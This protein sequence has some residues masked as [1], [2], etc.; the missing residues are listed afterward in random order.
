MSMNDNRNNPSGAGCE[1]AVDALRKSCERFKSL[2]EGIRDAVFITTPAGRIVEANPAG[3]SLFGYEKEEIADIRAED[4][5]ADPADRLRFK[6][7]IGENLSVKDFEVRMRKKDGTVL[8]CLLTFTL[9]GIGEDAYYQGIVRDITRRKRAETALSE[10]LDF[11]QVLIDAIPLPVFFKDAHGRYAGCNR[12]FEGFIGKGREDIIGKTVYDLSPRELADVY[13]EADRRLFESGGTQV[14]ESVVFAAGGEKRSVV[15]NKAAFFRAD[16]SLGGL[17]GTVFDITERKQLADERERLI[18]EF[19]DALANVKTLKGLLP[20]CAWCKKVRDDEGY[21]KE[22]EQY[23][24]EH[25]EALFTHGICE[26]C[27]KKVDRE[28]YE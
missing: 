28:Y 5:Y 18:S 22:V 20:I 12:A 16:G 1:D 24:E 3:L 27:L 14:Y 11:L 19:R 4:F 17:V 13:F 15:F 9:H 10:Q 2:F 8:D 21:W 6:K 23:I 25:S 26:D 7:E